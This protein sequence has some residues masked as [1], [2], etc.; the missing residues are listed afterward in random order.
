VAGGSAPPRDPGSVGVDPA[1][2]PG[3]AITYTCADTAWRT[4]TS[5]SP[6]NPMLGDD[7]AEASSAE[8]VP[9]EYG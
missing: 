1:G 9:P 2:P 4:D 3:P 7:A 6:S 8:R 5:D